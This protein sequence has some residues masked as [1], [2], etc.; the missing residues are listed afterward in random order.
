VQLQAKLGLELWCFTPLSTIFL[1]Y[2][3]CQFYWS[4]KPK[5]LEK[6][7]DLPQVPDKLYHIMLYQV[8]LVMSGIQTHNISKLLTD[9][10]EI[11]DPCLF[12]NKG[13]AT[14]DHF[15][16]LSHLDISKPS[17]QRKTLTYRNFRNVEVENLIS[18]IE[19][20]DSLSNPE[21]IVDNLVEK[22]NTKLSAIIDQHA[23]PQN[24]VISIRPNTKWYTDELRQAK[25]D[26][27]K[28]ERTMQKTKLTVHQQIYCNK[29]NYVSKLLLQSKRNYYSTKIE[30]CGYDQK[31]LFKLTNSLM[32]K[33]NEMVLPSNYGC[34]ELS[35][36]FGEYF[37]GKIENIRSKLISANDANTNNVDPMRADIKYC[38]NELLAFDPVSMEEV[39]KIV[40]KSASKS[41]ELDPIPTFL[42][43]PCLDSLLPV[44]TNII[45]KSLTE[46][47]V[48]PLFRKALVR[49]LIKKQGLD[50]EELK[51]YR[52][53]SNLP[54][55]SKVLEKAVSIRLQCHLDSNDLHDSVQ[56]A[57]RPR[58]STETAL[59][60][61]HHDIVT[62]LDDNKCA[63]L[64]M[65]D[66][67]AAF[68]VIDHSILIKRL[69]YS[70][71]I[72]GDA[73]SW[74]E[75]YL[76]NRTQCVSIDGVQSESF[77]L[78]YGVPQESVL[79]PRIYCMFSK[80]I[81]EICKRHKMS[82][83]CYAD[84]SQVYQVIK[85]I[86]NWNAVSR[87]FEA[88]LS[89]I[90]SWMRSNLLKINQDKTELIV[91]VPKHR[92]KDFSDCFLEFDGCVVNDAAFVKNLGMYFDKTMSMEKQVSEISR[93]CYFQIRSIGRIRPYITTNACK[94]LVA[95][96]VT[97]RLDYGNALLYRIND[98]NIAKL[99]RL[100]NTAARL[101]TKTRRYEHI[102]PVLVSL[103]WLP[104]KYRCQY[105]ILMYTFK[106]IHGRAP[107]Y[108][109]NLV[110]R[111]EPN[112]TLRS[113]NSV[114]IKK[115][116]VRTKT[117]GERRF[118][119][120]A[121]SLWNGL[122]SNIQNE[123]SFELFQKEVKTYL[124]RLAYTSYV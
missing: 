55:I 31:Q 76:S 8:H 91:F 102:T 17:R 6:T 77:N 38:G 93:S 9:A 68:D 72:S 71:G 85:P 25:R 45:N 49:R 52:P 115:P 110:Q 78:K 63:V 36:R 111:Y 10:L 94:T 28:A 18:D 99:Q 46:S 118:D 109:E 41:C 74:I 92:P 59:L 29:R 81:G 104:V 48:P 66:L 42:L 95:S 24:K 123:Q 73:L 4:R 50:P 84:D 2:H 119:V 101:I 96:L 23:P 75:S 39:R 32:G 12:D 13:N 124:F 14:R 64:V 100:Q 103:H 116:R 30:E 57:Y 70:Y 43:K 112:R 114:T 117:Y 62:A 26:R 53:V 65:L 121:S 7:T 54:F 88:C 61:V 106:A 105:K 51:N 56:S 47:R 11:L 82:Y 67:S 89:D 79:G 120:A 113:Q 33:T 20:S 108:L 16:L 37:V 35:N 22:Y 87:H 5:Y 107:V 19:K 58:H 122:P 83:H 69:Q 86:D 27:R 60:R 1:L 15:A 97:S 90:S 40:L 3:G 98:K 34:H 80:P 44:I 21:G